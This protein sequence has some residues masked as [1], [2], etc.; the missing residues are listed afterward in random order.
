MPFND[1]SVARAIAGSTLPL[2]SAIGHEADFTIAD[3]VADQRAATPSAAAE[4][5]TPDQETLYD[6]IKTAQ[7]R[8][9][10]LFQHDLN[11][12]SSALS[13]QNRHLQRLHPQRQLLQQSQRLDELELKL[14]AA[15]SSQLKQRNSQIKLLK[16]RLHGL[17]PVQRM[18]HHEQQSSHLTLRF[19]NAFKQLWRLKQKQLTSIAHNLHL[20]SPL[21]TLNRGYA[22]VT[23]VEKNQIVRNSNDVA[24]DEQLNVQLA[25][26]SLSC[27]VEKID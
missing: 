14:A 4:L 18:A 25:T 16:S 10:H 11:R 15:L 6:R 8:C 23:S 1:E 7:Q 17:S 9:C 3:F 5:A 24:V 20:V 12:K 2:I 22:L 26:G 13:N 21:H 27:K 19:N